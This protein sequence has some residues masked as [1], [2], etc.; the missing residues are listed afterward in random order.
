MFSLKNFP[1]IKISEKT[2]LISN[3]PSADMSAVA[4]RDAYNEIL[5][6]LKTPQLQNAVI[7]LS[8]VTQNQQK[9]IAFLDAVVALFMRHKISVNVTNMLPELHGVLTEL[10][11]VQTSK[12]VFIKHRKLKS[13]SIF[14]TIGDASLKLYE[15]MKSFLGFVGEICSAFCYSV[16]HPRKIQ[17]KEALYYMDRTGADG[18]PIVF[19]VCFLMG[20]ILAYQGAVQMGKFGLS[21]FVSDLVGLAII[22][23]LSALMVSMVCIGRAGSAFAAEIGTMQVSEEIDAMETMG[24]RTSRFLVIP[25]VIALAVVMPL[26]TIVGDVAGIL[27]G[28]LVGVAKTGVTFQQYYNRTIMAVGFQNIMEGITK[29]VVFAILIACV[30]CMMGYKAERDAKGVGKAAT[31]SVVSGV[32]LIVIADGIL[33]MI[34]N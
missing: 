32:F 24:L 25:K 19:L 13:K 15:D 10:G 14:L 21:I 33:T 7:D 5:T 28:T 1:E 3:F 12:E 30:G 16:L 31:S 6:V 20:A 18:V 29:S 2:L 26:L 17:W 8:G 22:K 4:T 11:F 23:E 34:F 9:A 27:G